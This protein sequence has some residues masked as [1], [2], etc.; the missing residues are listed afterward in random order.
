MGATVSKY[1]IIE[2]L[3]WIVPC[4]VGHNHLPLL[5]PNRNQYCWLPYYSKPRKWKSLYGI[6]SFV[7][8]RDTCT[9]WPR[10]SLQKFP[11]L[12]RFLD[13]DVGCLTWTLRMLEYLLISILVLGSL[14]T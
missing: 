9:E 6:S 10:I 4:K 3:Y 1:R 12:G 2:I 11:Q 13:L 8:C 5:L 14:D 7:Y